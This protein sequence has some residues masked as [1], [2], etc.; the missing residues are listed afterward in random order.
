ME[1]YREDMTDS[2][3]T[4]PDR[5][6]AAIREHLTELQAAR[7]AAELDQAHSSKA[8][9]VIGKWWVAAVANQNPEIAATVIATEPT[10]PVTK[11][12]PDWDA[13]VAAARVRAAALAAA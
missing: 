2:R 8:A 12:I 10:V 3:P 11:A 7:F 6:P 5:T 13:Q 9:A 4:P 1:G